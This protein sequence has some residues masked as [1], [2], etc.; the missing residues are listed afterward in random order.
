MDPLLTLENIALTQTHA[1]AFNVIRLLP[2]EEF[3][4]SKGQNKYRK[5]QFNYSVKIYLSL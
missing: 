1:S 2:K 3:K 4:K 5:N